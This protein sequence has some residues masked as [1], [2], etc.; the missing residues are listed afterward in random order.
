MKSV[1]T[2]LSKKMPKG[3]QT[4]WNKFKS[5]NSNVE[6]KKNIKMYLK[7]RGVLHFL[8]KYLKNLRNRDH[9]KLEN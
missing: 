6:I 2:A 1:K 3:W 4:V 9:K 8:K 5:G 7:Y